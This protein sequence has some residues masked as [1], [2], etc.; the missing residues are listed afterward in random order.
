MSYVVLSCAILIYIYTPWNW[1]CNMAPWMNHYFPLQAS[2]FRFYD[3][4]RE[5]TYRLYVYFF[6]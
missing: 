1:K 5:C 2:G 6:L 4:S 3:D